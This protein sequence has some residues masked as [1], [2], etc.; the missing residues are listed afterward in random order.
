MATLHIDLVSGNDSNDGSDW[1]NAW[2]TMAGAT[3][4]RIAPGDVIKVSKTSDPTSIGS[5]SWTDKGQSIAP[6]TPCILDI[7]QCESAWTPGPFTPLVTCAQDAT[8]YKQGTCS[9][10]I[11]VPGSYWGI[12]KAAYFATGTLD[13]SSYQQI[14]FWFRCTGNA[15]GTGSVKL[16]L[17]SDTAG[18]T[19]V[20]NFTLPAISAGYWYAVT[21]D[22]GSA[23][24]SSIGSIALYTLTD[25]YF[26]R[27]INFDNIIACKA[28]SSADSLTL[29]SLVS[30]N[31]AASGGDEGWYTIKSISS[32]YVF[33][34]DTTASVGGTGRGYSGTSETVTTYKRECSL[35]SANMIIDDSGTSGNLIE[36]QG[37]YDPATGDQDGETFLATRAGTF[38]FMISSKNYIKLR[39]LNFARLTYGIYMANCI[40]CD[41]DCQSITGSRLFGLPIGGVTYNNTIKVKNIINSGSENLYLSGGGV[42]GNYIE[43]VNI[44]NSVS[45]G[46]YIASIFNI[47]KAT[48]VNNNVTAGVRFI[49][50]SR[51]NKFFIDYIKDTASGYGVKFESQYAD[52]NFFFNLTT[53]GNSAGSILPYNTGVVENYFKNASFGESFT[54][55]PTDYTGHKIVLLKVGGTEGINTTYTDGG[56]LKSQNSVRNT[57][58]GIAWQLSPTSAIRCEGYPLMIPIIRAAV[59]SGD[60]VTVT[61]YFRRSNTGITGRLICKGYQ[62]AGVDSDVYDDISVAADTWEQLSIQFTPTEAGVVEIL[63]LAW[64]GTTYSVYVDDATVLQ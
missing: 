44:N 9:T 59:I 56:T 61:C 17:C 50:Q 15:I 42:N 34:D 43:C 49:D 39:R 5:A 55:G 38:Y 58:S 64:G 28:P 63:A 31:S 26:N 41:I 1:A 54:P 24:S 35:Q 45:V 37:G 23:L 11:T 25:E 30:K 22:N 36:F 62:I 8:Y 46:I 47:I 18:N 14:S 60:Q 2:L 19:I 3:A 27:V 4:A 57:A 51:G 20:H 53:S 10:K 48:N 33:L 7:D 32:S 29:N 52:K 6:S 40:G 12:N 13:L 16:C 21:L